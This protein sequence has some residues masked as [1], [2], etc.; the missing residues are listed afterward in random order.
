MLDERKTTEW[1]GAFFAEHGRWPSAA[2]PSDYEQSLGVWLNRQRLDESA[3]AMDP[4]R[5][6]Y[7]DQNLPGWKACPEDIWHE[8]A[9]ESSDFI[10]ANS[11]QPLMGA[12]TKGER[13]IAIWLTSQRA[14]LNSGGLGFGRLTWLNAHCLDWRGDPSKT[15][16]ALKQRPS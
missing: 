15:L 3:A 1:V 14:L 4:F 8:R 13:L 5:R 7:L 11:R 10:L 6:A 12:E 16:P 2:A 9:R